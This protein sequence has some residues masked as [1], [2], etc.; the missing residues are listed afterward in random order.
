MGWGGVGWVELI[1]S[2]IVVIVI[3]GVVV[4]VVGGGGGGG[5]GGALPAAALSTPVLPGGL[6]VGLAA[7]PR[8]LGFLL[9]VAW[10]AGTFSST[11][12]FRFLKR[13][14]GRPAALA[15]VAMVAAV[16]SRSAKI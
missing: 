3:V 4:V 12:P 11:S 8:A 5:G 6:L 1:V 13:G 9:V 15:R 16:L 7:G 10:P 2:V 14:A